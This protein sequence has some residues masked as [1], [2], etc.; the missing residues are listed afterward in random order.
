VSDLRRGIRVGVMPPDL[1]SRH[2]ANGLER[3]V[4]YAELVGRENVIAGVDCSFATFAGTPTVVPTIAW[5]KL[6]TLAEGA[7]LAGRKQWGRPA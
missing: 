1:G 3:I 4:R 7:R 2:K 6:G 5:A